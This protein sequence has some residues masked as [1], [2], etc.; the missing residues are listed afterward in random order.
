M[1]NC[2]DVPV[3]S[4]KKALD[5]LTIL[6]FEDIGQRGLTLTE[7]AKR[8][9]IPVNTTHNLLKTMAVC[10]FVAQTEDSSYV[11]GARAKAVGRFSHMISA[12][13][14]PELRRRLEDLCQELGEVVTLAVLANGRR[15]LMHK[16]DPHQ[17]IRV[18]S[19]VVEVTPL[20]SSPTGRVLCAYAPDAEFEAIL[21]RNGLPGDKWDG[22]VSRGDLEKA[23]ADIR[24]NCGTTIPHDAGLLVSFAVPVLDADGNLLAALGCYA[25]EFRCSADQHPD[26]LMSLHRAARDIA[27]FM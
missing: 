21:D 8:M 11:L 3:R 17:A 24:A 20:F 18:D 4:V 6:A 14:S 10:G 22:I 23:L 7:L 26:I 27:Q 16:S 5:L 2:K 19:I 15:A 9:A 13:A 12:A 25:P 1:A